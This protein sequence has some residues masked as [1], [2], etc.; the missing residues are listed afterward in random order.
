MRDVFEAREKTYL[1]SYAVKSAES[2]GTKYPE[3]PSASRTIFQRNR[4]R[5]V[6]A[7]AFR[8]LK[9]K[10]QVFIVTAS[11][12]YRSRLTHTLEV[13][14]ISRHLAR[15]L[16]INEDLCEV[17]A[18]AHD[19]GHTPFGHSGEAALNE[20]M[21]EQGGFEHNIQS[22]RIVDQ[23]EKKHPC[24]PGLNLSFEVREGLLKHVPKYPNGPKATFKSIEAQ[25]V[26]LADEIA[27]NNHDIDDGLY[28]HMLSESAL[29][30]N[31]KLFKE[32]YLEAKKR[33][34]N[35]TELERFHVT[36]SIMISWFIHDLVKQTTMNIQTLKIKT[37]ADVQQIKTPI[38]AMS[39][40]MKEKNLE[41]RRYLY[42]QFYQ[43]P[44]VYRMNKKGQFIINKLFQAFNSD[45][46]VLPLS[47]QSRIES[48]E[49][50]ERVIADY[51]AGMT[52]T[53]AI[54]EFDSLYQ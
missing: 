37:L 25:T 28:S 20:L 38:V 3:A 14:Q 2:Q 35:L 1:A 24:F 49:I 53:F 27:Y 30:D 9:H 41:L 21:K 18:L 6:H 4:D 43:H 40:E 8:R 23:L 15:L 32:A 45:I 22:L 54:K 33:H 42:T 31:I 34:T 29:I 12:H 36:N 13:A 51:I 19:L 48:G 17:I 52:D 10:T 7:K 39:K 46:K 5:V 11:D 16:N 47:F 50:K 26:N 44:D